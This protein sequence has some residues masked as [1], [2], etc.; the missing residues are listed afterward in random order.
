MFYQYQI[1]GKI[2]GIVHVI[3]DARSDIMLLIRPLIS[4]GKGIVM[5]RQ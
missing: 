2:K 3:D 4:I 5:D 1:C